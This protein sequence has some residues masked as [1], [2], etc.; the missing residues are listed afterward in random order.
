[1]TRKNLVTNQKTVSDLMTPFCAT[2]VCYM[3]HVILRNGNRRYSIEH[4]ASQ[5]QPA[6]PQL[7]RRLC[8]FVRAVQGLAIS[9]HPLVS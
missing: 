2:H 8:D 7:H 5:A 6:P 9:Q 1:M 4:N 3:L